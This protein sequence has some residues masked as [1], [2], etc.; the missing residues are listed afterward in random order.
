MKAVVALKAELPPK[1]LTLPMVPTGCDTLLVSA[2]TGA[3]DDQV[4][5]C[6]SDFSTFQAWPWSP[7]P[8]ARQ[9]SPSPHVFLLP[10]PL[11]AFC[12]HHSRPLFFLIKLTML[13]LFCSLLPP[14]ALFLITINVGAK[15]K[16]NL[17]LTHIVCKGAVMSE[18]NR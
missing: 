10:V 18:V 1:S 5:S 16:P 17:S 15:T 11:L 6:Q 8:S 13:P 12:F 7:L 3:E 9:A 2:R 14:R 4:F